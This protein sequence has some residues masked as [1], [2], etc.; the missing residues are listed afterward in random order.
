[1][2]PRRPAA[3]AL[4]LLL[5]SLLQ[6]APAAAI[7]R[8]EVIDRAQTWVDAKVPYSQSSYFTNKCGTY[9]QDCSGYVSMAWDLN[10]SYVTSTLPSV[11]TKLGSWSDLKPGDAVNHTCCH[12]ILFKA[13][14]QKGVSFKAY[15]EAHTG[16]VAQ[17]QDWTVSYAQSNGY[18]PYRRDN[19]KEC[20]TPHCDGTKRI[21]ENCNVISDC[22]AKGEACVNDA[23]GLRCVSGSCPALG[24]KKVCVSATM[25][26]TCKDGAIT[27]TDCAKSGGVCST[28]GV[29][30]ARCVSTSCVSS[31][32]QI[33]VA[34]DI[35]LPDGRIA[36]CTA[37]GALTGARSCATG[38]TCATNGTGVACAEPAPDQPAPTDTPVSDPVETPAT[39]PATDETDPAAPSL[40]R[41]TTEEPLSGGCSMT[42]GAPAPGWLL[43]LLVGVV[44]ALVRRREG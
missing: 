6:T 5:G 15:A 8:C 41:A 7:T 13:W 36:S 39:D 24:D 44:G 14:V 17:I 11:S 3:I 25:M 21:D 10:S 1:M 16:T 12:V 28:A 32:Q 38:Q 27:K 4:A 26:G 31:T 42:P 40:S 19:I 30:E 2:H 20:C 35:C 37:A 23:L 22:A 34:H 33:P 43:L 29:S 18:A 9:R